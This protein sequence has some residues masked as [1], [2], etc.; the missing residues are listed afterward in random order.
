MVCNVFNAVGAPKPRIE[1]RHSIFNATR[2]RILQCAVFFFQ[3]NEPHNPGI[4][5][6]FGAIA[7]RLTYNV[8]K[9]PTC[10]DLRSLDLFGTQDA[11]LIN[12]WRFP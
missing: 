6:I 1:D 4:D 3:C 5:N 12:S 9:L 11:A 10:S 7:M 8:C 2:S